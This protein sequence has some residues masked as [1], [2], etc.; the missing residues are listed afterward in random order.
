MKKL[1]L[2]T[3]QFGLKYG[4]ANKNGQINSLDVKKI[5]KLA[6]KSNIKLIDTAITYGNSEKIIG[7]L[8][9]KEFNIVSK[10]PAVPKNCTDIESWVALSVNSSLSRLGI[11]SL[12]ALLVHRSDDLFGDIGRNLLIALQKVKSKGLVKK[13]GI[14]IYDP[15]E[16]ENIMRFARIDIVQAPLN[17]LDQRLV[18]SGLLSKLYSEEI[19]IHTRSVFLQ[20]LLLMSRRSIPSKFNKWSNIWDKWL[21]EIE[22]NNLSAIEACLSYPLSFPEIDHVIVGVDNDSQLNEIIIK[23]KYHKQNIDWSIMASNDKDLINPNNWNV[24]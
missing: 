7:N 10:L 17:I 18:I 22:K 24:T 19:E 16:C 2:G 11:P 15:L 13:I 21:L 3:A 20:G 23:T 6:K 12:Y 8:G 5:L 9:I 14:S 4:V 1:A